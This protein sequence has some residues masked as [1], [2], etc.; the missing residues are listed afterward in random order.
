MKY[1]RYVGA[2]ESIHATDTFKNKVAEAM[3]GAGASRVI[4]LKKP[5]KI[6]HKTEE[7]KPKVKIVKKMLWTVPIAAIL[8][9]TMTTA[10]LGATVPGVNDF[11]YN[12]ISEGVADWM[13][14]PKL[15]ERLERYNPPIDPIEPGDPISPIEPFEPGPVDPTDPGNPSNPSN[16]SNPTQPVSKL[17]GDVNLDGKVDGSDVQTLSSYLNGKIN[18]SKEALINADVNMDGKVD[19]IDLN[20][21]IL[22][23]NSGK[24]FNLPHLG[25]FGDVNQDGKVDG[26]DVQT[27]RLYLNGKINLSKEALINA[28]VNMDGDVDEIDFNLLVL[29]INSG[30]SFSLPHLGIFGDVNLDGRVDGSDVQ[31]L[32][33]YLNGQANLSK[34]A[35]MNADVNLDG[36]VDETDLNILIWY[37]N[38]GR[39]FQLPYFG[40]VPSSMS[41]VAE[42]V[43]LYGADL[44]I[45]FK[46]SS[47]V[48][49]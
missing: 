3:A 21:L 27:L 28:D 15:T 22:Y 10:V 30:K 26:S 1:N 49:S 47:M 39:S 14:G 40:P 32:R 38:S 2:I 45:G 13:A 9:L 37:V 48:I 8:A 25:L 35:L 20:L 5:Q 17:C 6:N 41:M 4:D 18:L 31:T 44:H 12:N 24:N 16:P 34:A 7:G 23:V 33:L 19:K 42:Y 43:N 36:V 11:I 46:R 29:Y